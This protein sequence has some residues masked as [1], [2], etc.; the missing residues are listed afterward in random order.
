M[1][2]TSSLPASGDRNNPNHAVQ[3]QSHSAKR[4]R[5]WSGWKGQ[6]H[7]MKITLA[8]SPSDFLRFPLAPAEPAIPTQ[9]TERIYRKEVTPAGMDGILLGGC[10]KRILLMKETKPR[11]VLNYG[12][13]NSLPSVWIYLGIWTGP[14]LLIFG[15]VWNQYHLLLTVKS[16]PSSV[17]AIAIEL[18]INIFALIFCIRGTLV[19][20]RNRHA[21]SLRNF[22][23]L[24]LFITCLFLVA[25][26][27]I[28]L[29]LTKNRR[30][31]GDVGEGACI[32]ALCTYAAV[33][34]FTLARHVTRQ[35]NDGKEKGDT[36][37]Y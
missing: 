10:H 26:F 25:T 32:T 4:S 20:V 16:N 29:E 7:E 21:P 5:S 3:A 6:K 14:A 22:G 34:F 17:Q 37:P 33:S 13:P 24:Y 12:Q 8:A 35:I 1:T 19:A 23:F 15:V 9:F 31:W 2:C 30:S 27:W 28:F 11:L 18:L 36:A